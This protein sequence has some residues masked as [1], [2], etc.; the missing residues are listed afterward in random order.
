MNV[1]KYTYGLSQKYFTLP[2]LTD[3]QVSPSNGKVSTLYLR[4]FRAVAMLLFY[5]VQKYCL[6]GN[7]TKKMSQTVTVLACI[8]KKPSSNRGWVTGHHD[9]CVSLLY[10]VLHCRCPVLHSVIQKSQ[11][12][13]TYPIL[14]SLPSNQ[15]LLS[16][17]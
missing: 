2:A 13:T 17:V 15:T 10:S 5:I 11:L 3:H 9:C 16:L 8:Q 1:H 7:S 6:Q 4:I 14:D 12:P